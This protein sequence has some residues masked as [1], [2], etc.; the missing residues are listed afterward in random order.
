MKMDSL[1][2]MFCFSSKGSNKRGTK[3]SSTSFPDADQHITIQTFRQLKAAQMLKHTWRKTETY[4]I[5]E[6]SKSM[7]DQLEEVNNL[8]TTHTPRHSTLDQSWRPCLY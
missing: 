2:S 6:P 8:P 1:I 4:L 3:G 5:M 7:V